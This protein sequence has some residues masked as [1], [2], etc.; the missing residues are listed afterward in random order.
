MGDRPQSS[1]SKQSDG[2]MPDQLP[3]TNLSAAHTPA[4]AAPRPS[5]RK[6]PLRAVSCCQTA[7]CP[8]IVSALPCLEVSGVVP[9]QRG[10]RRERWTSP[11]RLHGPCRRP[12]SSPEGLDASYAALRR[13]VAMPPC[14]NAVARPVDPGGVS[15]LLYKPPRRK[16]SPTALD[17]LLVLIKHKGVPAATGRLA[18][19]AAMPSLA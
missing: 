10:D 11:P 18:T 17:E 15:R 16:P 7:A 5:T 8:Q 2:V 12:C 3:S 14:S 13:L 9:L 4:A 19:G 6:T 1:S